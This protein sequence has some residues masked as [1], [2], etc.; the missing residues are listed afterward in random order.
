M[1]NNLTIKD[2]RKILAQPYYAIN[3]SPSLFG[4]HEPLVTKEEWIKCAILSIKKMG[5]EKFLN[6]LLESLEKPITKYGSKSDITG[7]LSQS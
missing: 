1:N 5:P 6:D 3:I 2:I 4:E 7:S